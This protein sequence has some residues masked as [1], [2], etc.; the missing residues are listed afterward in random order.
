MTRVLMTSDTIGGVWTY[1]LDLAAALS[2]RGHDVHLAT[3]GELPSYAQ[4]RAA[5]S[6]G[7]TL[8]ER[9]FRLEW[10]DEPWHDVERAGKWLCDLQ[11][12]IAAD[13]VHLNGYSHAACAWRCPVVVV[14]HS[15]VCTWWEAV[16]GCEPPERYG[17]YRAKVQ[18]GLAAAD[19]VVTPTHA[20]LHALQRCHGPVR[21]SIVIPNGRDGRSF[22]PAAKQPLVLTAGRLWDQAKNVAMLDR[23]AGDLPWPVRVAGAVDGPSASCPPVEHLQL[24]GRLETGAVA[25]LMN[26]AAIYAHP[27]RYEPFG[28]TVLEAALAGCALVLSDILTLRELWDGRAVFVDPNN[29]R[30]WREA[31]VAL[32]H[33][34]PRRRDLAAAASEHARQFTVDRMAQAYID[35]YTT[36]TTHTRGQFTWPLSH[37]G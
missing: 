17:E 27:A 18:R 34:E 5:R 8:H 4:R 13:V 36:L 20:M 16:R 3:M 14:A 7:A 6:A 22:R 10:M 31:L 1:T 30:A 19:V 9:S 23:V 26:E 33:D 24:L 29:P 11:R 35:L 21:R 28:L 15:C 37:V 25:R 2:Q 32:M 12:T